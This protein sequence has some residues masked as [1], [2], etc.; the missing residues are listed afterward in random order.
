MLQDRSCIMLRFDDLLKKH[1]DEIAYLETWDNMKPYEKTSLV[2]EPMVVRL[3][4]YYACIF[5]ITIPYDD[6]LT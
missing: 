3:F 1:I 4:S 6:E 2:E 5:L